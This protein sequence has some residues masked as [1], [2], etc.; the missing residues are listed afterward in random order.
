M[1]I[2]AGLSEN[3][4]P[5]T[6]EAWGDQ[7]CLLCFSQVD[8]KIRNKKEGLVRENS[9][10]K[11]LHFPHPSHL[12]GSGK[13]NWNIL[14]WGSG[15]NVTCTSFCYLQRKVHVVFDIWAHSVNGFRSPQC[16]SE[17]TIWSESSEQARL[18]LCCTLCSPHL[19]VSASEGILA[20]TSWTHFL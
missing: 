2:Y 12:T 4:I 20:G 5:R 10:K 11:F 9:N 17:E 8:W 13:I 14:W 19:S 15:C 1:H 16:S 18:C 7:V 6:A 3:S